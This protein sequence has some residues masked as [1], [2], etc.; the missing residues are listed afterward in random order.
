MKATGKQFEIVVGAPA[1]V[2]SM[3]CPIPASTDVL[4]ITI[5]PDLNLDCGA[6]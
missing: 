3:S 2:R 4:E 1:G 5:L 6:S